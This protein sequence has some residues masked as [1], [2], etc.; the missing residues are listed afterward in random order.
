MFPLH[1]RILIGL[2][3]ALSLLLGAVSAAA[4]ETG[5]VYIV[6]PGD[7]LSAIAR[8]FGTTVQELMELNGLQDPGSLQSGQRLRIPGF[9][10]VSGVLEFQPLA[11]GEGLQSV[12]WETG[13][14]RGDLVRLNRV[15]NPDR[16][17]VGQ[18]I[19]RPVAEQNP[20]GVQNGAVESIGEGDTV[21]GLSLR[22]DE[23]P[24]AVR[25]RAGD[26]ARLWHA[27]GELVPLPE[28]GGEGFRA[29]PLPIEAVAVEPTPAEQGE[30]VIA[31]V[32]LSA[33]AEL[34]GQLG[35]WALNFMSASESKRIALQGV[36]ALTEPG[37]YLFSLRVL[38]ENGGAGFA[39]EQ[40]F[41]IR[42]GGYGFDPVLFVPE[43]TLDPE[44]TAP[45]NELVNEVLEPATLEKH[46]EAPFDFPTDYFT[47]SFPSLYGTRRNYNNTGY[48][49]YH[50]GLDF[51]GGTGVEILA[52][53]PGEV[54]LAEEL[55]VRGNTTIIDH[56]WGVYTIYMHQSEIAVQVGDFVETG[57]LI[58]YVGATGRVTGA[59]LHWEVRVGGVPVQPLDWVERAYP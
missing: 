32:E 4:Q 22:R 13:T 19:I 38:D 1:L 20:R 56:G 36:G 25:L 11:L 44:N 18:E 47:E 14:Q 31:S 35:E 49:Y 52:P 40:P 24:W 3:L 42:P 59:H 48:I 53:A 23:N 50:T 7:T 16:L 39:F 2:T 27:P 45:E 29:L 57:Q 28:E 33:P 46:W 8:T 55:I 37:L 51:Y 43:E 26:E 17:Y 15:L 9:E 6:Q 10:G 30:T 21:L 41:P 12:S 34:E 5:P 58:G 54:V